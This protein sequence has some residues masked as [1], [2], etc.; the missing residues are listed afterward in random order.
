MSICINLKRNDIMS[1]TTQPGLFVHHV[2][3]WLKNPDS[4]TDK[5]KLIEGLKTLVDIPGYI[6]A[7]IGFPANT[8]RPVIDRSYAVS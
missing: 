3:F 7:H 6:T 2:F 4:E 1:E 8:N 5:Q